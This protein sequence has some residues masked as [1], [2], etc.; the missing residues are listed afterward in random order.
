MFLLFLLFVS[1]SAKI[2]I[3]YGKG[4]D[5][6]HETDFTRPTMNNIGLIGRTQTFVDSL[7][8]ETRNYLLF[9]RDNPETQVVFNAKDVPEGFVNYE[10][11]ASKFERDKIGQF[12]F[13]RK[14]YPKRTIE[15]VMVDSDF[16]NTT[17]GYFMYCGYKGSI[18]T[19]VPMYLNTTAEIFRI[20][21]IDNEVFFDRE[22]HTIAVSGEAHASCSG[23]SILVP[24]VQEETDT[25]KE[26]LKK[27]TFHHKL[28]DMDVETLV[29]HISRL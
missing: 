6:Y 15:E 20:E 5:Q 21:S 22:N 23:P 14:Y 28:N 8:M 16:Y 24:H 26:H 11:D 7:N 19:P 27:L 13:E 3:P 2:A 4:I 9:R 10:I 25:L 12:S 17:H 29:R 18:I 1:C